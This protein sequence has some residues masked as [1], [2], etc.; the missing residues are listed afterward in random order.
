MKD[1]ISDQLF[2][3]GCSQFLNCRYTVAAIESDAFHLEITQKKRIL[4]KSFS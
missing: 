2:N 1:P 4:Y 3:G